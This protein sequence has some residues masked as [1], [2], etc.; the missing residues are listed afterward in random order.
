MTRLRQQYQQ[1]IL[2]ELMT[3]LNLKNR[4]QT[5]RLEKVIINV[6]VGDAKDSQKLFEEVTKNLAKISGQK[7]VVTK[8]KKSI[9]GFKIR[10]GQ[11]VGVRVTLRGERMYD[12]LDKLTAIALPRLRDF[13]GLSLKGFDGHGN[14]NLGVTEQVIFPE[15]P[16]DAVQ[17]IHGLNITVVTTAANDEQARALLSKLGLPFEK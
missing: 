3:E 2:A 16:F 8:A 7:P 10:A 12:F 15:I 5:P 9:A 13:R 17:K 6:G 1:T 14:Y 11:P 4:W